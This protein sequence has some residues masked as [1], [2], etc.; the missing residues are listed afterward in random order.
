MTRFQT[1]ERNGVDNHGATGPRLPVV[2]LGVGGRGA[3]HNKQEQRLAL[4][5]PARGRD[6]Q[7]PGRLRGRCQGSFVV[8]HLF[9]AWTQVQLSPLRRRSLSPGLSN[10]GQA[11]AADRKGPPGLRRRLADS[12]CGRGRWWTRAAGRLRG[13][14]TW[15]IILCWASDRRRIEVNPQGIP[16]SLVHLQVRSGINQQ[17]Q[18]F[19]QLSI[20]SFGHR[21]VR[22]HPVTEFAAAWQE[23]LPGCCLAILVADAWRESQLTLLAR[24]RRRFGFR[25]VDQSGAFAKSGGD[26]R[27]KIGA[28][29]TR[30]N[31][32]DGG[33]YFRNLY[34]SPRY[35][36]HQVW[37][38]ACSHRRAA[39]L[40]TA[41]PRKM[42]RQDQG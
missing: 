10:L 30:S 9:R 21:I 25:D 4:H 15:R 11:A 31:A 33:T 40:D 34:K 39:R 37:S 38:M 42:A 36:V 14:R 6:L 3:P 13:R 35:R 1:T 17:S 22:Y 2:L 19:R 5:W 27:P 20:A 16:V 41:A 32:L 8:P 26:G 12:V 7:A 23:Q 18:W 28:T 24:E 29:P